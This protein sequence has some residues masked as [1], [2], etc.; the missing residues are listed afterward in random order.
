[1]ANESADGQEKSEQPTAK[2]KGKARSEGQVPRSKELNGFLVLIT[3]GLCFMF[4]GHILL[5]FVAHTAETF[6]SVDRELLKEPRNIVNLVEAT[7]FGFVKT[8]LTFLSFIVLVT[9][10]SPLFM[11]GFNFSTKAF[12]PKLSKLNPWN[13][14]K[15]MF[16]KSS[17]VELVKAIGK[18][19]LIAPVAVMLVLW[20]A[21]KLMT[22]PHLAIEGAMVHAIDILM[23]TF[24][25]I[26]AA[27][28]IIVLID[29][30]FQLWNHN[31]QLKMT[32]QE[33]KEENKNVEGNPEVKGRIRRMQQERAMQRMMG[34]VAEADVV[35]TNPTHYAVALRYDHARDEAPVLLA[36]GKNLVAFKI[37]EIAE[38]NNVL[39]MESPPLARSIFHTTEVDQEIPTG[40]YMAVAKVLAYVHQLRAYRTGRA[41]RPV[42]PT[43]LK[44]PPELQFD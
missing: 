43:E 11:G 10:L 36:K 8:L 7:T 1:M 28:I 6:F 26:S 15:R 23:W 42:A 33:V 5:D 17:L 13:G 24:L 19:M 27:I 25:L 14:L 37:R 18:F 21:P 4:F 30:P 34:Q 31:E 38:E 12:T 3:G 16:S 29:V 40:L 39:I 2:K 32:K 20:Q 35:I 41:D 22:L 44:V 9:L